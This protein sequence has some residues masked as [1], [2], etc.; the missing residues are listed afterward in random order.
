[1]QQ[2]EMSSEV[3]KNYTEHKTAL[4]ISRLQCSPVFTN[5]SISNYLVRRFNL[6]LPARSVSESR[7]LIVF[8]ELMPKK[9]TEH[10]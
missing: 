5:S 8:L 2:S 10:P 6:M 7:V 9:A 1:M 4:H 3:S